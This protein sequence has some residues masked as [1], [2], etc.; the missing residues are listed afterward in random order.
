M[1]IAA[2]SRRRASRTLHREM[3]LMAETIYAP[4]LGAQDPVEQME[5]F[6]VRL[7]DAADEFIAAQLAT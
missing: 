6:R 1:P 5:E 2:C 7:L 3:M 4:W